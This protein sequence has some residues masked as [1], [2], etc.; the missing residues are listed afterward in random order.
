MDRN[1]N[2]SKGGICGG[3]ATLTAIWKTTQT[4]TLNRSFLNIYTCMK[5]IYTTEKKMSQLLLPPRKTSGV[6]NGLN[7]VDQ[8]HM[9]MPNTPGWPLQLVALYNLR[10]RS[11]C[12]RQHSLMSAR[13]EKSSWYWTQSFAPTSQC[14]RY[15]IH[16]TYQWRK[17]FSSSQIT[18]QPTTITCLKDILVQ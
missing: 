3:Q 17:V 4:P 8:D 13:M 15:C 5:G 9:E 1:E 6:R 2:E 11:C 12:W 16:F 7:L 14:L 18:L 10:L